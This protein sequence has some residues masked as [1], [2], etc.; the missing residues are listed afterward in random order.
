MES[1][2]EILGKIGFDW[3]VA[4]ANTVNFLIIFFLL[5]KFIFPSISKHITERQKKISEGLEKAKEAEARLKDIDALGLK[6]VREAEVKAQ[7]ILQSAVEKEKKM[8][9]EIQEKSDQKK[10]EMNVLLRTHLSKQQ[11]SARNEVLRQAKQLVREVVS[12]TVELSPDA[13][14]EALIGKAVRSMNNK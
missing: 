2:L 3:Q 5:K 13:I 4:L 12:K 7:I 9:R 8:E 6:T 11:E 1:L 14:D 10:Q